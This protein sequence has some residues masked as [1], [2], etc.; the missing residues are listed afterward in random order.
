[1]KSGPSS[2]KATTSIPANPERC[3]KSAFKVAEKWVDGSNFVYIK[4][5]DRD[6]ELVAQWF[7]DKENRRWV[8]TGALR[9]A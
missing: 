7:W 5:Y 6:G 4:K 3:G 1:M 8:E 2:K 9:R